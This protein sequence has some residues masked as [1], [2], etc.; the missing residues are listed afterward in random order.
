MNRKKAAD[1]K[2]Y[3]DDAGNVQVDG[4]VAALTPQDFLIRGSLLG[5]G[6]YGTLKGVREIINLLSKDKENPRKLKIK[7]PKHRLKTAE[8]AKMPLSE[9]V[10]NTAMGIGAGGGTYLGLSELVHR[11]E[12]WKAKKELE[13]SENH[14]LQSLDG[15]AKQGAASDTPFLDLYVEKVAEVA[16]EPGMLDH[17]KALTEKVKDS[18]A[19][20]A[21]KDV[22]KAWALATALGAGGL[23]Y[24]GARWK[25]KV[26]EEEEK[27]KARPRQLEL[28]FV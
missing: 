17:V 10:T 16:E 14:Y 7:V 9:L 26:R 21:M 19:S 24:G 8:T 23:V 4:G 6:A 5:A 28:E 12:R 13:E 27:R 22:T 15:L 2:V 1:E 3:V 25:D 18:E 11:Y 20:Q